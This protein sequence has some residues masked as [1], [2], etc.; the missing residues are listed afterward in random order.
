M[1][2]LAVLRRVDDHFR[3]ISG[4]EVPEA[5]KI[6]NREPQW[7]PHREIWKEVRRAI[8]ELEERR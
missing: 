1:D 5:C 6:V 4:L 8:K 2:P 7:S 3:K